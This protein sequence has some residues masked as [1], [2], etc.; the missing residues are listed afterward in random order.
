MLY[1]NNLEDLGCDV[2]V[3]SDLHKDCYGYRPR[4][5]A[6]ESVEA[7]NAEFDYLANVVLPEVMAKERAAEAESAARL[8]EAIARVMATVQGC[9]RAHAIEL[10]ADAEGCNGDLRYFEWTQGVASGYVT[11]R[12]M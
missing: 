6:F 4:N 5:I 10:L 8:E 11:G 2:S 9:T 1:T 3:Y 7:F 12:P